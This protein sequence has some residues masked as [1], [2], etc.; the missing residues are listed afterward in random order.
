MKMDSFPPAFIILL[1]Q[2]VIVLGL[3]TKV[4]QYR[5]DRRDE[6]LAEGTELFEK[7]KFKQLK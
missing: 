1:E 5:P 2:H 3:Q 4:R 7:K 6:T